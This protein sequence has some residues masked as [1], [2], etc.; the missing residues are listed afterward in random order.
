MS[1]SDSDVDCRIIIN[2]VTGFYIQHIMGT[3]ITIPE[4][5]DTQDFPS[6]RLPTQGWHSPKVVF[7]I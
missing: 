4:F 5:L 2:K 3:R 1:S 6:A 7:D